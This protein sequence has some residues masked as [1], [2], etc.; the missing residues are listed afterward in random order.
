MN[1]GWPSV[2]GFL[3][4]FKG[5]EKPHRSFGIKPKAARV[6]PWNKGA[7]AHTYIM[8][9]FVFFFLFVID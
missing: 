9:L 1:P 8:R 4:A 5:S 3:F 7:H 2:N 6:R